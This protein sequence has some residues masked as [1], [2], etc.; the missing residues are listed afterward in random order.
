MA[1]K[2]NASYKSKQK[3]RAHTQKALL[4]LYRPV[5]TIK[6][7]AWWRREWAAY[8]LAFGESRYSDSEIMPSRGGF[9]IFYFFCQS[10]VCR[11]VLENN[12]K[13]L[14]LNWSYLK[15]R[16]VISHTLTWCFRT[17]AET[18]LDEIIHIKVFTCLVISLKI[19]TCDQIVLVFTTCF[20]WSG[21]QKSTIQYE[22]SM[23]HNM[24]FGT[25][26]NHVG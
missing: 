10:R 6:A 2:K 23:K 21:V 20:L 13:V 16:A 8:S 19:K 12:I 9:F 4:I 14:L 7:T 5:T 24:L 17:T 1:E 25:L 3:A 22:I 15:R 11:S 18:H 26:S